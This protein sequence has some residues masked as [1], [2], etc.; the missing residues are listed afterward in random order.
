MNRQTDSQ[1][2]LISW[3]LLIVLSLIWGTS[4]ILIKKGLI[5]LTSGEVGALRI[6]AAA[7]FL[8]PIA[9]N[10]LFKID[11]KDWRLLFLLGFT[12]TFIPAFLFA[13]AQTNLDSSLTGVF[14]ALTPLW[15]LLMGGVF[16]SHKI[17]IKQT[18]GVILGFVGS[19]IL[20]MSGSGG[21]F[22]NIN[23]YALYVIAA[24]ILY[25]I[26]LNIIK[27]FLGHLKAK[28]ITS[29]SV[30][31]VGPIALVYL[32][33]FTGYFA[34]AGDTEGF[35]LATFYIGL[36]GV[37]ST[38]IALVIFNKIVQITTPIFASS[39]TYLIPIVA[40]AWGVLDGEA[41][42]V[43]HYIGIS[44]IMGGIYLVNAK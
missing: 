2:S 36:L 38:A 18:F 19:V 22:Q 29:V 24:T 12:G 7:I 43:S 11:R 35:W 20:I 8:S 14:N 5:V 41:L 1:P 37:M 6:V 31:F 23:Y 13:E 42:F 3:S 15:V 26:N 30:L 21:N 25:G 33:F 44:I 17:R 4:F 40:I 39:V 27:H 9:I 10:N 28:V 34:K 16:F 32:I